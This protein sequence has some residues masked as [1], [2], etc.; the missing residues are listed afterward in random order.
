MPSGTANRFSVAGKAKSSARNRVSRA[1]KTSFPPDIAVEID[2]TKDSLSE[3]HIYAALK[4]PP[5]WTRA[6]SSDR[7]KRS[8]RSAKASPGSILL[9]GNHGRPTRKS[10]FLIRKSLFLCG[11][12]KSHT[13]N[14][15]S[16]VGK[17][18]SRAG[19]HVSR[20][21][22]A[23]SHAGNCFSRAGKAKFHAGIPFTCVSALANT[24]TIAGSH[25]S[26]ES[27]A[28]MSRRERRISA[29]VRCRT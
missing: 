12:V 7:A 16:R 8:R 29:N 13:A 24:I 20:A 3:F 15:F 19:N 10:L 2:I 6:R 27:F 26:G 21:G 23:K 28:S 25:A 9:L 14:R 18:K 17:A 11:K 4:E 22:K 1:G 5:R